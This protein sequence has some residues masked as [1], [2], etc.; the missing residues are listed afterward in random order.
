MIQTTTLQL[1]G[2]TC[3]ACEKI[4]IRRLKTIEGVQD[5]RVFAQNG[6]T[7]VFASRSISGDEI[8]KALRD[9]HYKVVHMR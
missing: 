5:V 9:T 3:G 2:L 6:Q 1:S 7:S 8:T 4:I